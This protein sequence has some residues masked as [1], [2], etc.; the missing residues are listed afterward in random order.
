[1]NISPAT[2]SL[3]DGYTDNQNDALQL[4]AEIQQ[5]IDEFLEWRRFTGDT[6]QIKLELA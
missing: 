5:T 1:M 4:A 6:Q 3:A 2:Q